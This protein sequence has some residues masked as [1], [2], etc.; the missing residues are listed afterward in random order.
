MDPNDGSKEPLS[1]TVPTAPSPGRADPIPQSPVPAAGPPRQ[2]AP[3]PQYLG[4]VFEDLSGD[5][6]LAAAP[7]VAHEGTPVPTLGGIPLLSKLGQ[8]GMGAVYL[9][10]HPRLKKQVAVKVLP[11]PL[12]MNQ[13]QLVERFFREAQ[14][15]ARVHSDHLVG[16]LDVNE[17]CGLVYLVMELVSGMSAGAYLRRIRESGRRGLEEPTALDICIATAEGLAAAHREGIIHRDVKPDNILLP[18]AREGSWDFRGAKLADLG[19]ARSEGLSH[20]LT[21]SQ[22]TVGTPGYMAPE[23][24]KDARK[25]GKPADVYSMG[26]TLYALL[27]GHAPFSGGTPMEV[28]LAAI[29]QDHPPITQICPTVTSA[30]AAL[31]EHCLAKDPAARYV[32][33]SALLEGLRVCRNAIAEPAATVLSV[34]SLS[35]LRQAKEVG[36]PVPPPE[37][38][39]GETQPP[40]PRQREEPLTEPPVARRRAESETEPPVARRVG[41][42]DTPV[43]PAA[44]LEVGSSDLLPATRPAS[45]PAGSAAVEATPV[46]EAAMPTAPLVGRPD[47]HAPPARPLKP[48][49]PSPPKPLR[50]VALAAVLLVAAGI[51]LGSWQWSQ[52][53]AKP[54]AD[55]AAEVGPPPQPAEPVTPPKAVETKRLEPEPQPAAKPD[56]PKKVE[57]KREEAAPVAAPP[58]VAP[59]NEPPKVSLE[60]LADGATFTQGQPVSLAASASDPDG[61]VKSVRFYVDGAPLPGGERNAPPFEAVWDTAAAKPGEHKLSAKATDDGGAEAEAAVVTVVLRDPRVVAV[62]KRSEELGRQASPTAEQWEELARLARECGEGAIAQKA[63]REAA[64]LKRAAA[65]RSARDE[66]KA[67]EQEYSRKESLL[68]DE[69]LNAA[70]SGLKLA[71]KAQAAAP[72]DRQADKDEGARRAGPP[73]EGAARR[74]GCGRLGR[75]RGAPV[76]PGFVASAARRSGLGR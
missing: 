5:R 74:Q 64:R 68:P 24:A 13:P 41:G 45:K 43:P 58:P 10:I 25:A 1:A 47:T 70:L 65:Y 72:E 69:A 38:A 9:G 14:V 11:F 23:Q 33:A 6:L 50:A 7:Q 12:L 61:K 32:D 16:V 40:R 4:V 36:Q 57:P 39:E 67:T 28:M 46:G 30:T 17:E 15:A 29:Q 31:I 2:K 51:G 75:E 20:S 73:G 44:A 53:A 63:E 27:C 3:S 49:P 76:P 19:L 56:E 21:G 35:K 18:R 37:D 62:E 48:P 60:R 26:A 71:Q 52:H 55:R 34:Q 42:R 66:E 59:K 54:L 22:F 8:G